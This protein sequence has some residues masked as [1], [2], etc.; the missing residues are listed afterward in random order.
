MGARADNALQTGGGYGIHTNFCTPN[1]P[2]KILD[3]IGMAP[4]RSCQE[5]GSFQI[6]D[7]H[8]F[9]VLMAHY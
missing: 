4:L 2:Q 7:F 6:F 5:L 8:V 3:T 1:L 9:V